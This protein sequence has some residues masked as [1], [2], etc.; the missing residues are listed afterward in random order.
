MSGES[1]RAQRIKGKRRGKSSPFILLPAYIKQSAAYHG[2]TLTA[3]ALLIEL[4]YR[5]RGANNGTIGL[6]QREAA[7]ELG[8]GRPTVSRAMRELDDAGLAMPMKPGNWRGTAGEWRLTWIVCHKTGELPERNWPKAVKFEPKQPT[9]KERLSAA[10]RT[11]RWRLR[12]KVQPTDYCDVTAHD[13]AVTGSIWNKTAS[14]RNTQGP[15]QS[16]HAD[17]NGGEPS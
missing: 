15:P 7:Y 10:E 14:H 3:R 5:F 16:R 12:K 13:E 1:A 4:I 9:P 2:L 17:K 6:G 8:C 11:R